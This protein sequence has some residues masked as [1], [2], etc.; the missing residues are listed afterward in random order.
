[1]CINC[2]LTAP[3]HHRICDLLGVPKNEY[4]IV[5]NTFN[6]LVDFLLDIR[7]S[8][9]YDNISNIEGFK[10]DISNQELYQYL[11]GHD[12]VQYLVP[13]FEQ[14]PHS[15]GSSVVDQHI[16]NYVLYKYFKAEWNNDDSIVEKFRVP[17]HLLSSEPERLKKCIGKVTYTQVEL[18]PEDIIMKFKVRKEHATDYG[19]V[20][21]EDQVFFSS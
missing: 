11:K 12:L 3:M 15:D 2:N 18:I 4:G 21:L 20:V 10:P 13:L 16:Y 9:L 17:V 5:S 8:R 7:F 1:M 19:I 6:K 14:E